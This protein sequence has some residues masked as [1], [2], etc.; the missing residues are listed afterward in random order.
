MNG[1]PDVLIIGGGV[2]GLTTAY[3]LAREGATVHLVERGE[4]GREA[5]WAGAGIVPPGNAQRA[6][7]P[8][9]VLRAYSSEMYPALSNEL[10]ERTKIDNGY[11]VCGG[12]EIADGADALPV[13]AW[14]AEGI[15]F[16]E[17][18]AVRLRERLPHVG[19]TI[20]KSYFLPGMA[21]VRNPRH[22]KALVAGCRL[23]GVHLQTDCAVHGF[24]REAGRISA[25][26]TSA[27][28]LSADKYVLA[29]GAWSERLL[30]EVGWQPGVRPVRGQ[31]ALLQAKTAL[32]PILLHGKRYVVPRTDGRVLV[33]STEEEA[34]FDARPTASAIGELL[35]FA[36]GLV[37]DL[38]DAALEHCWAGLRP[39]SPD[40]MPFLGDVPGYRNLYVAAG[41]YRAGIQLSPATGWLLKQLLLQQPLS[42]PIDAFRL[43]RPP[44]P[45][46]ATAFHS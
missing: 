33:G 37:P 30:Q 22:L 27:G 16:E 6:Q 32:R 39:G 7:T 45:P 10:R 26:E 35:A 5:S 1:H 3:Y 44:L 24:G 8:Y 43:D 17:W 11:V 23:L 41:H 15:A 25:V 4:L 2:I 13:D 19:Q 20:A 14:R 40:G 21:Q 46:S 12:L 31:M 38:A 42:L 28:R 36:V 9:D 18:D 34:G 29:A